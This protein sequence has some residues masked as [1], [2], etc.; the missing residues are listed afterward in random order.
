[1]TTDDLREKIEELEH[2]DRLVRRLALEKCLTPVDDGAGKPLD[3]GEVFVCGGMC[4]RCA[5][6]RYVDR[7]HGNVEKGSGS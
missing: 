1:M 6:V 3:C 4:V 2:A 7:Y 5:A